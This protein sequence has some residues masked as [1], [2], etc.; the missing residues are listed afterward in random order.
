MQL[1]LCG[2]TPEVIM[3]TAL[4]AINFYHQQSE[5]GGQFRENKL[6]RRMDALHAQC[7]EKLQQVHVAYTKVGCVFLSSCE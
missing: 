4:T 3:Q 6:K 2:Q 7:N 1:A 5:L